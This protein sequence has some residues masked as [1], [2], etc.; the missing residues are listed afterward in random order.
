MITR[1]DCEASLPVKSGKTGHNARRGEILPAWLYQQKDFKMSVSDRKGYMRRWKILKRKG[2]TPSKSGLSVIQMIERG[3]V[4][5]KAEQG[6]S[7]RAR[8]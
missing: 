4:A 3:K 2:H 7:S 6:R 1:L 8:N 5:R